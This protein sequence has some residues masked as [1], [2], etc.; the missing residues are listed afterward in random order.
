MVL[1]QF[2]QFSSSF[3]KKKNKNL[4]FAPLGDL[5]KLAFIDSLTV[6]YRRYYDD[7]DYIFFFYKKA[8]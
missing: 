7:D 2:F 6:L 1:I 4:S 3:H 8:L 5:Q